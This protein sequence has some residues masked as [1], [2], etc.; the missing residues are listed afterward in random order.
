MGTAQLESHN[1]QHQDQW[2]G[3]ATRSKVEKQKLE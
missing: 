2:I 3:T 1:I